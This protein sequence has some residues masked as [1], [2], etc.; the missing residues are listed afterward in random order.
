MLHEIPPGMMK[1]GEGGG[2]GRLR[3]V[4]F[5]GKSTTYVV[6]EKEGFGAVVVVVRFIQNVEA[7]K[8]ESYTDSR[9]R[10]LFAPHVESFSARRYS[11]RVSQEAHLSFVGD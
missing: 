3:L 11:G 2:E 10:T 5:R 8:S 4:C 6:E 1:K 7:L 9:W